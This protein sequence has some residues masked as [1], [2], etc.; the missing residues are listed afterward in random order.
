MLTGW[1]RGIT[2]S[3]SL[4]TAQWLLQYTRK[5]LFT[6]TTVKANVFKYTYWKNLY[7][8]QKYS[9]MI[10]AKLLIN[11]FAKNFLNKFK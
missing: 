8:R 1:N 3:Q 4:Q 6:Y 9:K 11:I 2:P 5:V 10:L 7:V